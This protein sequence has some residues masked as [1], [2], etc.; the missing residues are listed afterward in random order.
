MVT[1]YTQISITS[2]FY[3]YI[4]DKYDRKINL[5]RLIEFMYTIALFIAF[6]LYADYRSSAMW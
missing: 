2:Q 5:L 1:Q 4:F 3:L 6:G